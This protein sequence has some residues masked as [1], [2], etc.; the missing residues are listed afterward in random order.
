MK[1]MDAVVDS[2]KLAAEVFGTVR[3][4]AKKFGDRAE[5]TIR[6]FSEVAPKKAE[7]WSKNLRK[8][9]YP[10]RSHDN[11]ALQFLAGLGLGVG[12]ALLF[13]PQ[14]GKETR[15]R[16]R[17]GRLPRTLRNRFDAAKVELTP[18]ELRRQAL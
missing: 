12:A 4:H 9:I 13:A 8:Q 16:L 3:K 2:M 1:G 5:D 10:Q 14:S 15:A 11:R 18:D 6:D 7:R 17:N